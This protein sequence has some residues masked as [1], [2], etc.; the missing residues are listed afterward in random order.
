MRVWRSGTACVLIVLALISLAF[1]VLIAGP[2]G[3]VSGAQIAQAQGST[4]TPTPAPPALSEDC[5]SN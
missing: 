1:G 3:G 4:P 2:V 5:A